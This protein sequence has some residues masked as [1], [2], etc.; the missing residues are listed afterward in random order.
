MNSLEPPEARPVMSRRQN[1]VDG[2]LID[3]VLQEK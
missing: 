1:K 3:E 2:Q